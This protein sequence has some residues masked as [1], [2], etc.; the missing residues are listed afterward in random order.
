M[1]T[2]KAPSLHAIF[3]ASRGGYRPSRIFV[4]DPLYLNQH[5]YTL[6]L[7]DLFCYTC[8]PSG[9]D[10]DKMKKAQFQIGEIVHTKRS[11][12]SHG[13]NYI[14]RHLRC[15]IRVNILSEEEAAAEIIAK[16]LCCNLKLLAVAH[17]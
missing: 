14:H 4:F 9:D 5:R 6:R 2:V 8:R 1:P 15:A 17:K 11:V 10:P 7:E 3:M 12:G 16:K 13:Q